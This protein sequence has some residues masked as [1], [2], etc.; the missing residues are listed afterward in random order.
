MKAFKK[1]ALFLLLALAMVMSFLPVQVF[2]TETAPEIAVGNVTAVLT[3]SDATVTVPVEIKNN[4][5]FGGIDLDFGIPSGWTISKIDIGTKDAYSIFYTYDSKYGEW[6]KIV[7]PITNTE[8]GSFVAAH[9]A[10][11]ET[12]GYLCWITYYIPAETAAGEYSLTVIPTFINTASDSATDI[13][14]QFTFSSGTITV[15]RAGMTLSENDVTVD[16]TNGGTVFATVISSTGEDM[17]AST[18]LSVSPAD[19]GVTVSGSTITVVPKA[20][21]GIYTISGGTYTAKLTV[22]R[23]A[24]SV[25]SVS[26]SPASVTITCPKPGESAATQTFNA[27]VYNQYDETMDGQSIQWS[28]TGGIIDGNGKLTIDNTVAAGNYIVTATVSGVS[29]SAAVTV[30]AKS[31]SYES[32]VTDP[33]CTKQGYTTHTCSACGDSYV[34]SYVDATGHSFENGACVI[35]GK[36]EQTHTHSSACMRRD[37]HGRMVLVCCHADRG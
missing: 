15:K 16:G 12:S 28:A 27:T 3:G 26:V 10:D 25:T 37:E 6:K 29:G 8:D 20:K 32:V 34:D 30:E 36:K 11:I 19:G 18:D 2:A 7:T 4:P 31:H 23:V 14:S 13:S 24:E 35:C 5:G 21:A 9:T 1:E 17:T 33:T 22:N